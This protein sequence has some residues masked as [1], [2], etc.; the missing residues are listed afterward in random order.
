MEFF[1]ILSA[2]GSSWY[3]I[4][5]CMVLWGVYGV[6]MVYYI[7]SAYSLC[8]PWQVYPHKKFSDSWD[9]YGVFVG[10][11]IF[12][13]IFEADGTRFMNVWSYG[14]SMVFLWCI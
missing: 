8:A 11:S 4:H 14:V 10:L 12:Y 2:F 3:T 1:D 9:F 7:T 6:F 5:E 13:R